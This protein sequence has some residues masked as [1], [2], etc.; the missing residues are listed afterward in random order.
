MASV[1]DE[2]RRLRIE[3]DA[4]MRSVNTE[5]LSRAVRGLNAMRNA[6]LD[7]LGQNGHGRRYTRS[8]VTHTASAP[9]EP[10]APNSGNLR[11][12]WRRQ[13]IGQPLDGGMKITMRMKSEMP[14]SEH[15]ERGTSKIAPR[16]YKERIIDQA[17]PEID[18]IFGAHY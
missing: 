5:A 8:N 9:G 7:V 12:R 13:V 18:R 6:E 14:Y 4:T 11:Q 17:M 2:I 1:D 10:P 3:V 16:P 15:L